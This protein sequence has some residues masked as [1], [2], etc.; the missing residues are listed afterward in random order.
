MRQKEWNLSLE[1][2]HRSPAD[3]T[4]ISRIQRKDAMA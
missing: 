1:E 2:I 3:Y 4:R